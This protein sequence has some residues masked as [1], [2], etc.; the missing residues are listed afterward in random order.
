MEVSRIQP[1][2][3]AALRF[4]RVGLLMIGLPMAVIAAGALVWFAR[5]D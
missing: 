5:R 2:K 1:I 3:P 4:W